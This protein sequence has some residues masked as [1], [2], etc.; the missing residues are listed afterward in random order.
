MNNTKKEIKT[1]I[2]DKWFN[3]HE[4]LS[5]NEYIIMKDVYDFVV[6]NIHNRQV[7]T[8]QCYRCKQEKTIDNFYRNNSSKDG[9]QSYCKD[10]QK[11]VCK[12]GV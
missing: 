3:I 12:N 2:L 10:C 4:S 6:D 7:K 11:I 5:K 8:K 9:L 1:S